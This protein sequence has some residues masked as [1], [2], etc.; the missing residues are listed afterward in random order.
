MPFE[1]IHH[2]HPSLNSVAW[3]SW[4]LP[5]SDSRWLEVYQHV[6]G[7]S[8]S[9]WCPRWISECL[10]G[11]VR[12]CVYKAISQTTS[13]KRQDWK[14]PQLIALISFKLTLLRFVEGINGISSLLT[15]HPLLSDWYCDVMWWKL[16]P[17]RHRSQDPKSCMVVSDLMGSDGNVGE[18]FSASYE[19]IINFPANSS[20]RNE[21]RFRVRTEQLIFILNV[22]TI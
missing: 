22:S 17:S 4:F 9:S 11:S 20:Q 2:N 8:I 6:R 7:S 15:H 14:Q 21:H 18:T 5:V 16:K 12:I 19:T 1:C 10:D 3:N 13:A